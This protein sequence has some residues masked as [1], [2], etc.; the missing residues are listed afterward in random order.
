MKIISLIKEKS[1]VARL[2]GGVLVLFSA[3][4]NAQGWSVPQEIKDLYVYGDMDRVLVSTDG[5]IEYVSG[6]SSTG[7][8]L[9]ASNEKGNDRIYSALLAAQLA[10]KKVRFWYN[11]SCSSDGHNYFNVIRIDDRNQ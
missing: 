2:V 7:W 9:S 6:C 11:D 3:A 8:R 5:N 4:S 1:M 10:K